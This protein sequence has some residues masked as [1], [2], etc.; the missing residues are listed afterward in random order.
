MAKPNINRVQAALA[1]Y[2]REGP[3]PILELLDPNVE[4]IADRSDMGR[5]SYRGIEAVRRSFDQLYEGF[6]ELG[7]EAD[8][9]HETGNL[10]VAIGRMSARGRSTGITASIPL[11]IVLRRDRMGSSS[12]MSPSATRKRPCSPPGSRSSSADSPRS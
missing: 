11:G 7:F 1:A 4:W 3:E 9:L 10:V 12:A 6:D 2:N 5:V 8:E